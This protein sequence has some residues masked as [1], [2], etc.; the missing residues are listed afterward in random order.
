MKR[1][2]T[3]AAINEAVAI[4]PADRSVDEDLIMKLSP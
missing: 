3:A 2:R 1:V 4:L